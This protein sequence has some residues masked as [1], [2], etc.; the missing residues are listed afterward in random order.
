MTAP[1]KERTPQY[2]GAFRSFYAEAKSTSEHEVKFGSS[3]VLFG[4]IAGQEQRTNDIV[5][6]RHLTT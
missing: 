3:Y 4:L 5:G 2:F 1:K 6:E